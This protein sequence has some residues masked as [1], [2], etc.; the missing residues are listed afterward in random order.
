MFVWWENTRASWKKKLEA[1]DFL[2]KIIIKSTLTSFNIFIRSF[3]NEISDVL[4]QILIWTP[5]L[6]SNFLTRIIFG[7]GYTSV[8]Y[9]AH[10]ISLACLLFCFYLTLS[11]HIQRKLRYIQGWLQSWCWWL[12]SCLIWLLLHLLLQL[13]RGGLLWVSLLSP[14]YIYIYILNIFVYIFGF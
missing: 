1:I 7:S 8:S 13:S 5:I 9:F 6:S 3:F 10:W 11:L 12:S 4:P 2:K 14:I